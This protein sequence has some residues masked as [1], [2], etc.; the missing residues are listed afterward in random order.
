MIAIYG[1][2]DL[3][4]AYEAMHDAIRAGLAFGV[5]LADFGC[6]AEFAMAI[7]HTS[8]LSFL[9][10]LFEE[11]GM[12]VADDDLE[13]SEQLEFVQQ[14]WMEGFLIGCFLTGP[15]EG[16]SIRFPAFLG[17]ASKVLGGSGALPL[18]LRKLG[19]DARDATEAAASVGALA[20]QNA[21][22]TDI[23]VEEWANLHARTW[24]DALM[25][26]RLIAAQ[27]QDGDAGL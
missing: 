9:N 13:E 7:S 16:M 2:R 5:V 11:S 4:A 3:N 6:D 12:D 26:A 8:A 17:A 23:S 15:V 19:L 1:T 18:Q 14:A 25:M 20:R 22:V 27:G 21:A 10:A 24:L